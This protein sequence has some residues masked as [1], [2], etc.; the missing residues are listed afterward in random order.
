MKFFGVAAAVS[1]LSCCTSTTSLLTT[2]IPLAKNKLV[3]QSMSVGML[4]QSTTVVKLGLSL[5]SRLKP[6]AMD[7]LESSLDSRL[8]LSATVKL[9]SLLK[10]TEPS[11]S[12]KLE[13][14][15]KSTEPSATDKLESSLDSRLKLSATVKL[16]SLLE[17]TEPSATVVKLESTEPIIL[18]GGYISVNIEFK[19]RKTKMNNTINMR[20]EQRRRGRGHVKP[21]QTDFFVSLLAFYGSF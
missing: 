1:V 16:E 13:T 10:S 6:S 7:K 21:R 2:L 11:A 20:H 18:L 15:L 3:K 5:D 12:V 9:E 8:K 17:S 14:L 4:G 19:R